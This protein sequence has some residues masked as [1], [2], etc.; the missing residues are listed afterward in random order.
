MTLHPFGNLAIPRPRARDPWLCAPALRRVCRFEDER[1]LAAASPPVATGG[2]RGEHR[3]QLSVYASGLERTL[4][5]TP[6]VSMAAIACAPL[7]RAGQ[8]KVHLPRASAVTVPR[9]V[10][11]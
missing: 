3:A 10:V 6:T 5:S 9:T 7:A 8:V 1:E 2:L 4:S 11:P